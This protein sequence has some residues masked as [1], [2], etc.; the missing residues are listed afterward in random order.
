MLGIRSLSF[1]TRSASRPFYTASRL[2]LFKK[3]EELRKP[4][5]KP[6]KVDSNTNS[7]NTANANIIEPSTP[8][9]SPILKRIPK[10]MHKYFANAATAP[11][12]HIT[13]FIILHEFSA[14]APLLG[15][16][17]IIYKYNLNIPMDVPSWAI[18]KGTAFIDK[19]LANF[20]FAQFSINDKVRFVMA[21]GYSYVIVKF[22]FPL[23]VIF[24]FSFMPSFAKYFVLPFTSRFSRL[25]SKKKKNPIQVDNVKVKKIDKPRL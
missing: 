13:A 14:I 15:I 24:S 23:R 1:A 19:S 7:I 21:G 3:T 6:G 10:F 11:F 12:S 20:D 4:E 8:Q 25:F 16:W 9:S 22:L 18:D 2:H 5:I 17:Y